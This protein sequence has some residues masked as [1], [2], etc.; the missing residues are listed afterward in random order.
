MFIFFSCFN[1]VCKNTNYNKY[2]RSFLEILNKKK[3][4]FFNDGLIFY[5]VNLKGLEPL[6]S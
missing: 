5:W 4:P 3:P 1:K 2:L 6:T